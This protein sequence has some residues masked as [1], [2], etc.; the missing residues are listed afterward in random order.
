MTIL[1][2]SLVSLIIIMVIHYLFLYLKK[3]LTTPKIK[4]LVNKPKE[5]YKKIYETIN[6]ENI[7]TT[8]TMNTDASQMNNQTTNM[9][10]NEE[11]KE[12][13]KNELKEYMKGLV[14]SKNESQQ[15]NQTNQMSGV[16]G[17]SSG[18]SEMTGMNPSD[19][20]QNTE[21]IIESYNSNSNFST[22]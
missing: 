1:V 19:S 11:E 22:F 9:V 2:H 13:R 21:S 8:S 20:V 3:N 7:S 17:L 18:V 14:E 16:S 12:Q 4:D 15:M 6:N 10:N 5:Q